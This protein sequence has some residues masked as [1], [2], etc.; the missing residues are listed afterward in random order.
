MTQR[1]KKS[2]TSSRRRSALI[3]SGVLLAMTL[4]AY[5][6][7][8]R[9]G[10]IWDD[11]D[12][13]VNNATLRSLDGLRQIWFVPRATPQYYPLVH[14]SFWIEYQL[15]RLNPAGYHAVN[16][17]L[18]ALAAVLLWRVLKLLDVPGAWLA[19]AIFAVHP[20]H[21]ESVAW[22]TE[23]KNVLSGVFY[24]AAALAYFRSSFGLWGSGIGEDKDTAVDSSNT[25]HPKPDTRYS[26][27]L[28]LFVCALLSKTVTASLPATILL[29]IWWKRGRITRRDVVPLIP[30][31]V[32]GVALALNTARLEREHVGASGAEF[33]FSALDR[34]L[35]AGR[36]AWFYAWK[37][38]APVN[39]S[40]IYP[41]WTIDDRAAWQYAFP[42]AAVA[43]VAAL[44]VLRHRIGRGP[45]VAIL[46]F[47][48]TLVPALGFFNVYPMRYTFVADH[49][50]YHASIGIIV[51]IAAAV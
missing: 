47:G 46:F 21:V 48:G 30:F 45:L 39:L 26:L 40:F 3:G 43:L 16:V 29:V 20:M 14:T 11:P 13:V 33:D 5:L 35:I 4:I 28:G 12:Y 7:A 23:R 10:F 34:I 37:L 31:F 44:F 36:A 17:L 6:P 38:I 8:F 32:I 19:A 27:S 1:A 42:L 41:R 22:V 15:W 18:H 49:F 51:L 24:L 2:D 9:A 25:R 50:A